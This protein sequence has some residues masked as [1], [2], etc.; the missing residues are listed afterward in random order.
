MCPSGPGWCGMCQG[1]C[2]LVG[3]RVQAPHKPQM[4]AEDLVITESLWF[5]ENYLYRECE[6]FTQINRSPY[7]KPKCRIIDITHPAIW[8]CSEIKSSLSFL[9]C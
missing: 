6:E 4:K 9:S 7:L 5:K 1:M 8:F 3:Q 2:V